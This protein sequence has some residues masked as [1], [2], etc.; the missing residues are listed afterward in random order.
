MA[1]LSIS[2]AKLSKLATSNESNLNEKVPQTHKS[3]QGEDSQTRLRRA[4]KMKSNRAG[5]ALVTVIYS[6]FHFK[7]LSVLNGR[8]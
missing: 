2:T 5:R 7:G 8:H 4:D 6:S 1:I 3:Y